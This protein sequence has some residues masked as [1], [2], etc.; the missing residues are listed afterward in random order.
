MPCASRASMTLPKV[1][2]LVAVARKGFTAIADVYNAFS[3]SKGA[4]ESFAACA[5]DVE[6]GTE[7]ESAMSML[8]VRRTQLKPPEAIL[9]AIASTGWC[10]RPSGMLVSRC[11]AQLTQRSL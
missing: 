7:G 11:P 8:Y 6:T 10:C 2:N 5:K 1:D 9:V 3:A 4:P